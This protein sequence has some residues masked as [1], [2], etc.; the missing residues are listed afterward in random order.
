VRASLDTTI[1][2]HQPTTNSPR[3]D[4]DAT[5]P[6][7]AARPLALIKWDLSSIGRRHD[8]V[9]HAEFK[10]VDVSLTYR[11]YEM[12]RLGRPGDLG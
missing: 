7:A 4:V 8:R 5:I 3:R 10:V 9:G 2:Q 6:A 1:S 12:K 11:V